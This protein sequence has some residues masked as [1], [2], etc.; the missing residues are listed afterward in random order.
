MKKKLSLLL[1]LALIVSLVPM[2]AF[3][4]SD[5][6]VTKV[7]KTKDDAELNNADEVPYVKI[8]NDSNDFSS[9]ERIKLKLTNAE[10]LDDGDEVSNVVYKDHSDAVSGTTLY[11]ESDVIKVVNDETH[12][13]NFEKAMANQIVQKSQKGKDGN[14]VFSDVK[15]INVKR[16]SDS[17]VEITFKGAFDEDAEIRIPLFVELTDKGEAKVNIESIDGNITSNSYA[18]AIGAGG[19]T[20]TT[21]DSAESFADAV[22]IKTIQI[23]EAAINAIGR[24][25]YKK[26]KVKLPTNFKWDK[27]SAEIELGGAF[28]GKTTIHKMDETAGTTSLSGSEY[29]TDDRTLEFKIKVAKD[30]SQTRGTIY[31]KKLNIKADKNAK[32]GD[33]IATI[34]GDDVTTEDIT[35]AKY[36]DYDI[37][38]K[39]T[40]DPKELVAGQYESVE[41]HE[42]KEDDGT[43]SGD[44]GSA[45]LTNVG[46]NKSNY[47]TTDDDA[48]KLAKLKIEEEVE[49]S[50]ITDRKTRIEFPTWVKILKVKVKDSDDLKGYQGS[51]GDSAI[52]KEIMSQFDIGD[53]YAEFKLQ[54]DGDNPEAMVELQ[55]YVSVEAGHE[56]DI[57]ATVGGNAMD[58][59]R[60]IVLGKAVKPVKTEVKAADV[61]TGVK[62]QAIDKIVI[63]EGKAEAIKKENG[64]TTNLILKL[65]DGVKWAEVPTIKVTDGNLDL[66]L[67]GAKVKDESLTIPVKSESSKASTIEITDAKV[68]LD[69]SVPE[70]N[71]ELSLMGDAVVRNYV[72]GGKD[73]LGLF[74]EDEADKV[75]VARVITPADK[76]TMAGQEVKFVI[77]NAE[78]Q[79]GEVVKNADVAPYIKDGRTMLSVRYV[80]EAM[81][82]PEASIVWNDA[83][84]TVTV[85]KGERVAQ[86]TIGSPQL[87]VNG[88]PVMMD[89]VA[90]I[91]DGRTMLPISFIAKALGAE[92][93][94]DAA[95]QTVTIK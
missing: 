71:I 59:A 77:G 23:D 76:N 12:F 54:K 42:K 27:K 1:V 66:D 7:L 35:I 95:T 65:E 85:F 11:S 18:F 15:D 62:N 84:R 4:S 82:V 40:E 91:K 26:V 63:K 49:N 19:D 69:R 72:D 92:A 29:F 33:V 79:V 45:D 24:N 61:R 67:T 60:E 14:L 21:I 38:V 87:M 20:V 64:K 81:G 25:E 51:T 34:S 41:W 16:I 68:D 75:V 5:N 83:A 47:A 43:L 78:Y 80:A 53:N 32:N 31:I 94:W 36:V 55:F 57:V 86:V 17:T 73:E 50:W 13:K 28:V 22:E 74:N 10:W 46:K 56:G 89:T 90:E 52:E 39:A 30:A 93:N 6:G 48:H 2:S 9:E 44:H 3:A 8:K 88:T 58:K 37:V 70:G